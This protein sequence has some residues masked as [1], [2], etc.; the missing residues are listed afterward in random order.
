MI[1]PIRTLTLHKDLIVEMTKRELF[2]KHAGQS[3]GALWVV[4]HPM[5]IMALYVVVFGIVF[6]LRFET[7]T[8]TSYSFYLLCGLIPWLGIVDVVNKSS[9]LLKANSSLI[10]QVIFPVETLQIKTV[11]STY[12]V[13]IIFWIML[14]AYGCFTIEI[15]HRVILFFIP[16]FF[17]IM[18]LIGASYLISSISLIFSDMKEVVQLLSIGGLYLLPII[19]LPGM[20]SGT[21]EL[22]IEF[23][24]ISHGVW[25]F[26]DA[27]MYQ[28]ITRPDSWIIWPAFSITTYL[29]GTYLFGKMKPVVANY[30]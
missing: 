13:Q 20:I 11:I 3:I 26:R 25:M 19:Y 29:V 22:I 28:E 5:L 10:R 17:Y 2:E 6:Q 8:N 1:S 18:L 4:L 27:L 24:P 7:E 21:F 16:A 9:S 12:V 30:V 15:T 14:L 23:N